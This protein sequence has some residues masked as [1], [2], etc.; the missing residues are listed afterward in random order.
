M[1]AHHLDKGEKQPRC[2]EACPTGALMF[3]DL[4]DPNSDI[5]KAMATADAEVFHP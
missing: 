2:V 1:C 4:D 3:G 5:A